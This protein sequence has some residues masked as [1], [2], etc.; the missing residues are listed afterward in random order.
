MFI[1]RS[2]RD[3]YGYFNVYKTMINY[4]QMQ[5]FCKKFDIFTHRKLAKITFSTQIY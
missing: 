4:L 2:E 3:A 1:L 5:I